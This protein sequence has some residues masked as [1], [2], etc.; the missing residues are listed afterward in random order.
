MNTFKFIG[1]IVTKVDALNNNY[2]DIIITC[3]AVKLFSQQL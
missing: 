1:E 2:T 3:M